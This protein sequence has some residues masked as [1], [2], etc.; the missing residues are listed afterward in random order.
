[1]LAAALSGLPGRH[2]LSVLTP[3][4]GGRPLRSFSLVGEHPVTSFYRALMSPFRQMELQQGV[5]TDTVIR[6]RASS[7]HGWHHGAQAQ[8]KEEPGHQP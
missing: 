4:G 6:E 5:G 8:M 1:M 2:S 3:A 7:Q